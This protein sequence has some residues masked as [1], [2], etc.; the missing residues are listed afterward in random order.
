MPLQAKETEIPLDLLPDTSSDFLGERGSLVDHKLGESCLK[1]V[2]WKVAYPLRTHYQS[3]V[4]QVAYERRSFFKTENI[5]RTG[6]AGAWQGLTGCLSTWKSFAPRTYSEPGI[7]NNLIVFLAGLNDIALVE[8]G[9]SDEVGEG[10]NLFFEDMSGRP[11]VASVKQ[12][13]IA[14]AELSEVTERIRGE[15]QQNMSDEPFS[16]ELTGV[17]DDLQGAVDEARE[18]GFPIPSEIAVTNSE[19]LIKNL[20]EVSPGRYGVYPTPDGEIAIDIFNGEGSSVILLC[21]SVGGALCLVNIESNRR[22]ARYSKTGTLP[23]GFVREALA[24]LKL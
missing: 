4:L 10:W 8:R 20:Y 24:E 14:H 6:G 18:E 5:L 19:R 22:R 1:L 7:P 16:G 21:D 17:L 23:D 2:E 3:A 11:F 15:G 13:E 12:A 9:P